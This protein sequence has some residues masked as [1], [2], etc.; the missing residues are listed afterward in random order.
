MGR[1]IAWHRHPRARGSTGELGVVQNGVEGQMGAIL[2][3]PRSVHCIPITYGETLLGALN[4]ESR[5]ESAFFP[6]DVLILNTLADLLATA[7]HNALFFRSCNSNR[8]RR[9]DGNQNP[10]LLLGSFIS[11]VERGFAFR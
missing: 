3:S 8:S 2:R 7:L 1:R 10:A 6:Q 5:K 4:I 11:R 9:S